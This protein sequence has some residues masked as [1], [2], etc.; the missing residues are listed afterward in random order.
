MLDS[1]AN[2]VTGIILA[3]GQSRRLGR[4]KILLELKERSLLDRAICIL[5][6]LCAEII[7]VGKASIASHAQNIRVV[8]DV[9]PGH[10]ALGGIHAGLCALRTEFGLVVG[11]DMP[12]LNR[13]LLR[14]MIQQAEGYDVI[15]PCVHELLEPL[16]AL[17][18]HHC[19]IPIEQL[20]SEGGGRIVSFFSQVSVRYI[21]EVEVDRFDPQHR[22]FFNINTPQDWQ[23]AK[24]WV[25]E[26][27]R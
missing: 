2:N 25:K 10:G 6:P 18:S 3:G 23:Q 14:H 9:I 15:I 7:V 4:D 13:D 19:L 1:R 21:G 26:A 16:H 20:L 27:S 22:S 24:L 12:F 17:Y 8:Q 11:C 5:Y